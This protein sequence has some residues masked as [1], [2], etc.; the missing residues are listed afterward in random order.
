[1]ENDLDRAVKE[2][3]PGG[4]RTVVILN[5]GHW[6]CLDPSGDASGSEGITRPARACDAQSQRRALT[7]RIGKFAPALFC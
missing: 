1:M 5:L 2:V 6:Q 7:R 4:T 3:L